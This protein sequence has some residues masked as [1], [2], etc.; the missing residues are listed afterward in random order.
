MPPIGGARSAPLASIVDAAAPILS[1]Q[2][3][4]AQAL[5]NGERALS[6][7]RAAPSREWRRRLTDQNA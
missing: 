6:N 2:P 1:V 5:P 4:P 3:L 7:M